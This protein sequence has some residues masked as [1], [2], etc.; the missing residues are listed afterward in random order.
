MGCGGDCSKCEC[1][2]EDK[3]PSE[4]MVHKFLCEFAEASMAQYEGKTLTPALVSEIESTMT[5]GLVKFVKANKLMEE[6]PEPRVFQ[7][8]KDEGMFHIV[9]GEVLPEDGCGLV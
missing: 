3:K 4:A 9:T 1:G 6:H 5:A 2:E 8:S 7:C